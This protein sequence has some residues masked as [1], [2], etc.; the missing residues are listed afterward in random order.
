MSRGLNKIML[1]GNVGSDPEV[2]QSR[3]GVTVAKVSL[4]TNREW[5]D[6]DG[7]KQEDVQWHRLTFFDKL[8]EIV[9][10]Y[11]DKGDRLYV[12]G[13]IEYSQTKGEDGVTRYWTDVVV[14]QLI[15]LGSSPGDGGGRRRKAKTEGEPPEEP[16]DGLPF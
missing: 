7:R 8:G 12:E 15:M 2:R 5:R 14:R 11:V 9:E 16:D 13:R 4:A 3:S 6:R 1:I 10:E